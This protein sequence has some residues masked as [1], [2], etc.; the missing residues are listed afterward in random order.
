MFNPANPADMSSVAVPNS[1]KVQFH[2]LPYSS[3]FTADVLMGEPTASIPQL[4]IVHTLDMRWPPNKTEYDKLTNIGTADHVCYRVLL[5][6]FTVNLNEPGD[7]RQQNLTFTSLSTVKKT[8]QLVGPTREGQHVTVEYLLRPRW[9]NV[10]ERVQG[11]PDRPSQRGRWSY[12]FLNAAAIGLKPVRGGFYLVELKPGESKEV[13][14]EITGAAMPM[15]T[16]RTRVGPRAGGAAVRPPSGDKPVTLP[17]KPGTMLTLVASGLVAVDLSHE[18]ERPTGPEGY[19]DRRFAEFP[20]LMGKA[21]A[22]VGWENVGALIGSF[23]AFKTAFR[24][25]GATSVV[26]PDRA[27]RLY[28]A[29]NDIRGLYG[30]NKGRG[31]DVRIVVTD[32]FFL[33]TR[34]TE[35]GI[36]AVG[37]PGRGEL[38]AN[39]P[40]LNIDLLNLDARRRLVRPAGYVSFAAFDSR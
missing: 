36:P 32:P 19:P 7:V 25:G 20:M 3:G 13:E 31:Y 18:K 2:A 27:T 10:P 21:S 4:G 17:V 26:V 39:I 14:I 22:F 34:L 37:L 23:D 11:P 9:R 38:G 40:Q 12:R 28:L 8:F 29:V 15:Q 1:G 35:V 24:I 16:L 30:D 5:N 33:P 6:G